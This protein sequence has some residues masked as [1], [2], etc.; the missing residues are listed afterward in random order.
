MTTAVEPN[1]RGQRN[2][3]GLIPA[4]ASTHSVASRRRFSTSSGRTGIMPGISNSVS[5][6]VSWNRV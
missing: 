4:A 3:T 5:P 1:S 6:M 2:E